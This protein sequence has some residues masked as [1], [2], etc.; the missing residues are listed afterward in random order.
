MSS[1]IRALAVVATTNKLSAFL[2]VVTVTVLLA[3]R[4]ACGQTAAPG[5][6]SDPTYQALRNITLSGEGISV[7]NL[8][9]KRDVG[10]F[11]LHS[12]TVCF[13]APVNGKV[14]GAVFAGEG[15][16]I[17]DPPP[18]ERGMLKLLTK[19]DEF[20]ESFNQMAIRF[21]DSTYEEIKGAGG[22]GASGCDAGPLKDSQHTTRHKLKENMEARILADVLS[23]QA[24]GLFVAFIHGN[25]TVE[26]K[27]PLKGLKDKPHRAVLSYYDDVL[28]SSN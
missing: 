24:G 20:S 15:N 18:S 11:K 6:N 16:F 3:A 9:L 7:S 23:P 13:V 10:T 27:V 4:V 2:A 8:E 22:A 26:Q 17:L 19:E 5:A 21:T 28:A 25:N 12:G 1:C 14:T